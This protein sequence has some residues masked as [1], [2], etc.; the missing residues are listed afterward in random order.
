MAIQCHVLYM[1]EVF[2]NLQSVKELGVLKIA[3]VVEA[4]RAGDLVDR[5]TGTGQ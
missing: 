5:H 1:A 4:N 3:L 2:L